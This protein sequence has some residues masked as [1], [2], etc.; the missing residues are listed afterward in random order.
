[1]LADGRIVGVKPD[2]LEHPQRGWI[3]PGQFIPVRRLPPDSIRSG[4]RARGEL[5]TD[6]WS[7]A[8]PGSPSCGSQCNVSRSS[9]AVPVSRRPSE[10]ACAHQSSSRRNLELELTESVLVESRDQTV[11]VLKALKELGV[12][13]RRGRLRDGLFEL[14]LSVRCRSDCL[15]RPLVRK[16]GART[17]ARRGDHAR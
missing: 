17:R 16:Q 11:A 12:P 5:P 15:E 4:I 10:A 1:V 3:P 6:P 13:D 14:E 8:R 2:A 7:G 9:S